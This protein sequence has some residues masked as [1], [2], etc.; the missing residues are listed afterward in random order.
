MK[1]GKPVDRDQRNLQEEPTIFFIR[2]LTISWQNICPS[3]K[4]STAP[5]TRSKIRSLTVHRLE[6]LEKL[7][8]TK[9]RFTGHEADPAPPT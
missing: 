1:P 3:L 5:L 2:S 8:A 4:K 6:T 9:T 7:F